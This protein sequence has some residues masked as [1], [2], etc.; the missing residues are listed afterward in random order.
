MFKDLVKLH[1]YVIEN[2]VLGNI[3]QNSLSICMNLGTTGR[4]FLKGK[5][6]LYNGISQEYLALI[7]IEDIGDQGLHKLRI[8]ILDLYVFGFVLI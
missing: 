4:F 3:I 6:L 7:F 5:N 1:N 2:F 8:F